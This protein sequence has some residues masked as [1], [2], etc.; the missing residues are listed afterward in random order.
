MMSQGKERAWIK[1][2]KDPGSWRIHFTFVLA[3]V[4]PS[5]QY[6]QGCGALLLGSAWLLRAQ[7][8]E[9]RRA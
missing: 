2:T 1:G 7:P 5:C 3:S 9:D 4:A 8:A 6:L